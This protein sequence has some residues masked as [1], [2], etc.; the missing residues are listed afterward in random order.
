MRT[1]S[2]VV[3]FSSIFALCLSSLALH[4]S[5]AD[6]KIM[7]PRNYKGSLEELSQEAIIIFH[8]SE[9]PGDAVEDLILKI[10]VQGADTKS[11]GWVVPFPQEP[12]I[13]KEDPALFKEVFDYVQARAHGHKPEYK[14]E[15]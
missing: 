15:S 3:L 4:R 14:G 1:F 9:K 6:G 10:S 2:R 11:F 12:K 8:G 5:A 13:G 7:P